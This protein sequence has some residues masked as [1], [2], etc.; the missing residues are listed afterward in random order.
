MEKLAQLAERGIVATKVV[1]SS[2]ILLTIGSS[3]SGRMFLSK[4]NDRRSIRLLP[5]VIKYRN[6]S[7]MREGWW[8]LFLGS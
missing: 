5:V 6:A 3:F 4:R 8:T 2:P 7:L 1:G